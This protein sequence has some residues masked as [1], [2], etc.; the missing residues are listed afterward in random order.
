MKT[1]ALIIDDEAPARGRL[2]K[3]LDRE[4]DISVIGECSNG[5][6]A[7]SSIQSRQPDVIFLDVQMPEVNGFDVLRALRPEQLPAVIFVTAHD[8]HAVQAFE[9][10]ALDYLLKPFTQERL[11]QA[12]RRAQK[13]RGKSSQPIDQLR[14]LLQS[15]QRQT[16][17]LDR[18]A[19]KNSSQTVF[20]KVGLVDY[21]ESAANYVVVRSRGESYILRETLSNLEARLPPELFLRISRSVIVNLERVKTL[22]LNAQGESV[23]V[24]EDGRQ[25]VVTRTLREVQQRLQF[26]VSNG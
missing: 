4:P 20:V 10:H 13:A 15:L 3:M 23:L 6:E 1:T 7:I 18:I 16:K 22:Q 25:L 17:Y 2:R 12:L 8:T 9:V 5:P 11:Q 24:L 19:I 14:D 21:L 26:G